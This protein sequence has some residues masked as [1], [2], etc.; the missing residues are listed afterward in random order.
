MQNFLADLPKLLVLTGLGLVDIFW[1]SQ[2][3][4]PLAIVGFL[5]LSFISSQVIQ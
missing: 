5:V 3:N 2:Y 4:P 1:V